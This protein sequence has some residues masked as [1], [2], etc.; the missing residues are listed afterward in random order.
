[1]SEPIGDLDAQAE[2]D[3][4]QAVRD[5][6]MNVVGHA[7][8]TPM[9]TVRG[10][11]EVLAKTSDEATRDQLIPALLRS[12]RRLELLLDD[13]LVAAG[14]ETRLPVGPRESVDVAEAVRHV[15]A[16]LA[17]ERDLDLDVDATRDAMAQPG[18]LRW[19]LRH[20]IDNALRYGRGPVEVGVHG[21][22]DRLTVTV[23]SAG[24]DLP[25][26]ELRNAFELFYR[27]HAAVMT[28]GARMGVGLTVAR[29]LAAASG[30]TVE[31]RRREGGGTV[32]H[33]T[34]ART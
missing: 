28:D 27:G 19:M 8:R 17:P 7:L 32:A 2:R 31:L 11:V 6:V 23:G 9:A 5:R 33:L 1:M 3:E 16:E 13:V 4:L 29:E 30:G 34:L 10:Q 25:D 12:T 24:D 22:R 15:W 14:I 26:D 21:D 18:A 20:L